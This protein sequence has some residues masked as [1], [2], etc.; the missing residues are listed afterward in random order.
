MHL[1]SSGS[2]RLEPAGSA[3]FAGILAPQA[4]GVV[5]RENIWY[6]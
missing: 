5:Q 4:R 1:G 3:L 6:T 2:N